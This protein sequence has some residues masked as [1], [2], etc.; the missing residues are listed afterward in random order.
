VFQQQKEGLGG[1]VKNSRLF[2]K[3]MLLARALSLVA[4][5]FVDFVKPHSALA[6][7]RRAQAQAQAL[8]DVSSRR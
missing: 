3:E 4:E 1:R 5:G 2:V 6:Q 8:Q 7:A